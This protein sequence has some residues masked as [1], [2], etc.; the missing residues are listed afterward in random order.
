M[1]HHQG[2]ELLCPFAA[3]KGV[4]ANDKTQV[5]AYRRSAFLR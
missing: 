5:L 4:T 1:D 2:K 3:D